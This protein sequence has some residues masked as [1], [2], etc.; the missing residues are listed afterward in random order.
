MFSAAVGLF[1]MP[2]FEKDFQGM[3]WHLTLDHLAASAF[4][5]TSGLQPFFQTLVL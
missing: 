2:M 4:T 3:G 1:N 5:P